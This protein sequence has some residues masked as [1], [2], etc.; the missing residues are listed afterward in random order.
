VV[1]D[2]LRAAGIDVAV[3]VDTISSV[4]ASVQSASYRIV[5]EALTNVLRHAHASSVSVVV[6]ADGEQLTIVVSD[7]GT[8]GPPSS[9]GAGAGVRGMRERAEALGGSL[10]AGPRPEGGWC[11]Q[12]TLPLSRA[13][14]RL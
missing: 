7:D 14:S 8:G 1:A 6:R 9:A 10:E 4:P 11:V 12:A 3:D 5:Q 2:Q 13:P